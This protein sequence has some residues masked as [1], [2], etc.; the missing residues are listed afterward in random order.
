MSSRG[1]GA[2]DVARHEANELGVAPMNEED[3]TV[4]LTPALS[5]PMGEGDLRSRW[6]R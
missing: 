1:N 2:P 6:S 5:Y 3:E 4:T